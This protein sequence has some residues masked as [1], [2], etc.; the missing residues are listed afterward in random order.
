M[1]SVVTLISASAA[2]DDTLLRRVTGT[3]PGVQETCWLDE[4]IA[5]DIFFDAP[6]AAGAAARSAA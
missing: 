5:A 6:V 2:L 4:G 3:L 1:P